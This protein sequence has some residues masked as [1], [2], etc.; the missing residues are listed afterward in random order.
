[1]QTES[2][3]VADDELA[4]WAEGR[5]SSERVAQLSAHVSGCVT[6]RTV[7]A[8]VKRGDD[9]PAGRTLGRYE[10]RELVGSGGMGTVYA[11]WDPKLQRTVAVKVLHEAQPDA[12]RAQR[13]ALEQQIL[14]GLEHPHIARLIDTGETAEGRAYFVME[15]VD[16]LPI[17]QFCDAKRASVRRRLELM[18]PVFEAVAHAHQHLVVHRDL[19]P[20]NILVTSDGVPKLVDFGIARLLESVV[21]LAATGV[22]PM[23]PAYAS[24]EQVRREPVATTSDVYSLGVVLEELL[25]GAGPYPLASGDLD[26]LL[27]AVRSV[28]SEPPSVA[29]RRASDDAVSRRASS[30]GA[31][32]HALEGDV[33]AIVSMALRKAPADRYPSVQALADDVR[34]MLSGRPTS[35]RRGDSWYRALSFVRRYRTS[36]AAVVAAFLAL[37]AGLVTTLWQARRAEAARVLA[38]RRFEQVRTLAHS[39]LFDYHDGIAALR[40]STSMRERLVKDALAYL[41]SLSGEVRDDVGLRRE[42]AQGYLKVGDV[43][44]DPFGPSLGD[45]TSAKVSYLRARALAQT[46]PADRAAR[47]VVAASYQKEGALLEVAGGLREALAAYE[48]ARALDRALADAAPT[49][50]AQRAALALDILSLG[51]VMANLGDLEGAIARHEEA[52]ALRRG[53]VAQLP[54]GAGD[55]ELGGA[56]LSFSAIRREQGQLPAAIALAE[57]AEGLFAAALERHPDLARA[58]RALSTA[59]VRLSDFVRSTDPTRA[60]GYARKHLALA[61]RDLDDDPKN[62]VARRDLVASLADL[63]QVL[64]STD[65]LPEAEKTMQEAASVQQ[66]LLVEDPANQQNR[67]DRCKLLDTL[68]LMQLEQ[69]KWAAATASANE[70]LELAT[71]LLE[72]DPHNIGV[73]EEIYSAHFNLSQIA[74]GQDHFEVALA[75]NVLARKAVEAALAQGPSARLQN[76]LALTY[77]VDGEVRLEQAKRAPS[78]LAWELTRDTNQKTVDALQAL[79]DAGTI[80]EHAKGVLADARG[81]V[82]TALKALTPPGNRSTAGSR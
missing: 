52:I 79:A 17:D 31:L 53:L 26:A 14:A 37:T 25:A 63:A 55:I 47:Q 43:Q 81:A 19:K 39:V 80:A 64:S 20:G 29:C 46:L 3:C 65:A 12:V 34:A 61:R 49:D 18:L 23:T 7:L 54:P 11:A 22:A 5:I 45:T 73:Q 40:G 1:M 21:G 30:R 71:R 33:D 36:V 28:E 70:L 10:L 57:E 8:E 24:P 67:L 56:L 51:Q 13:F 38:E 72:S 32:V 78:R 27:S 15:F 59:W 75:E 76:R 68:G 77:A 41:D 16:G 2:P 82:A 4:A 74:A 58:R 60:M 66:L 62:A 35:A 50:L 9:R 69:Q 42:V 6:C 48:Q 44:G